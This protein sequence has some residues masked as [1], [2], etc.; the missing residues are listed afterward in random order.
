MLSGISHFRVV[1]RHPTTLRNIR[2]IYPAVEFLLG[3]GFR[4]DAPYLEGVPYFSREEEAQSRAAE[5]A[6][7]DR[8]SFA[9]I[10]IRD[11][12]TESLKFIQRVRQ[13]ITAWRNRS[14]VS[15]SLYNDPRSP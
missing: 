7:W 5:L 15:S 12:D 9:D 11:G 4:M 10:F 8:N 6:K 3:H 14:T 1:V 2:L 13:E